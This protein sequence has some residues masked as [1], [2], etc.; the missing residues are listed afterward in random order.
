MAK[1][2]LGVHFGMMAKAMQSLAASVSTVQAN[3]HEL[4]AAL[5]PSSLTKNSVCTKPWLT[6]V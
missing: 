2:H 1:S 5:K 3:Q 6:L 4:V